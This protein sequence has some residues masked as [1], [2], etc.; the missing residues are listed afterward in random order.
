MI[1]TQKKERR[2]PGFDRD[3]YRRR[4]VIERTVGWLKEAR[5][6]ATRFEKLAV[7]YL[8]VLKLA[9]LEKYLQVHLADKP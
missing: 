1:P 2:R 4:N 7:H 5:G 3:A 8:A 6:L 9:I